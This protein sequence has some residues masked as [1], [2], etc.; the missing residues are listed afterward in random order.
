MHKGYTKSSSKDYNFKFEKR[1]EKQNKKKRFFFLGGGKESWVAES[2]HPIIQLSELK[3][4]AQVL[5][6]Q[7][8]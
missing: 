7:H 6:S 5:K 1:K 2:K 4:E 3:I 8:H